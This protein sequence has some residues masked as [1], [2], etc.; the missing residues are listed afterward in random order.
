MRFCTLAII[1]TAASS[2]P[3]LAADGPAPVAP[4]VRALQECRAQADA[5][6]RLACYDKAV[7]ALTAATDSQQVVVIDRAEVRQARKGL[8]GFAMPR[9]GFLSGRP[10]NAEDEADASHL[11]TTIT[12]VRPLAYGKW[13]FT[14]ENGGVWETT[15][16]DSRFEDPAVGAKVTIEKGA[17][18]AYYAKVGKGRRVQARRIA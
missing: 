16:I 12:K 7:D 18:G 5:A 14:V 6:P 11:D 15:E 3:L 1:V 17:L 8:F 13:R 10:G 2:A 4:Q 9:I